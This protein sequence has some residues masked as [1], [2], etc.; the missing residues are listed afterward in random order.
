MCGSRQSTAYSVLYCTVC[1][2]LYALMLRRLSKTLSWPTRP[3][4]SECCLRRRSL[5]QCPISYSRLRGIIACTPVYMRV[6]HLLDVP[7]IVGVSTDGRCCC[8]ARDHPGSV[9]SRAALQLLASLRP[10]IA[11]VGCQVAQVSPFDCLLHPPSPPTFFYLA[12]G[13]RS[14]L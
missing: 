3:A 7:D 12:A 2:V 6:H 9:A 13:R 11:E 8:H 14:V 10:Q 5:D 4:Y 1:N